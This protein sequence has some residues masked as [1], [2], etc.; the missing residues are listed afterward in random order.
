MFT[1]N[2]KRGERGN[3]FKVVNHHGQL[4]HVQSEF[5]DHLWPLHADISVVVNYFTAVVGNFIVCK[6]ITS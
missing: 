5:L 6:S 3:A 2:K 4:G 1:A